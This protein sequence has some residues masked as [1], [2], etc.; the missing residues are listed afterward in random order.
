[1]EEDYDDLPRERHASGLTSRQVLALVVAGGVAFSLCGGAVILALYPRTSKQTVVVAVPS[2]GPTGL[3]PEEVPPPDR[4]PDFPAAPKKPAAVAPDPNGPTPNP[5]A[6]R[7]GRF[8]RPGAARLPMSYVHAVSG[9][10]DYIGGGQT[11][12]FA[13]DKMTLIV[14]KRGV[15]VN[16]PGLGLSFGGPGD[17]FL[18]PGLHPDARRLPFSG[19]AP[20]IEVSSPGRGCNSI[21]GAFAVWEIEVAGD[22]VIRLAIDFVQ[23]C[24]GTGPPLY[25]SIRYNS[26]FK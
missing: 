2:K 12:N 20:G 3:G 22:R 1:L 6:I 21:D 17:T 15:T 4:P 7:D 13:Q 8:V 11:F 19:N 5:D 26:A 18:K 16:V 25:G 9:K 14:T 10:E 24:E 23:S